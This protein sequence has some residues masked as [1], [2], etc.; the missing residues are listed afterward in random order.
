MNE[1]CTACLSRY[2]MSRFVYACIGTRYRK[3]TVRLTAEG[4]LFPLDR[5]SARAQR[6]DRSFYRNHQN[7][8]RDRKVGAVRLVLYNLSNLACLR[9]ASAGCHSY[10]GSSLSLRSCEA[11]FCRR[12]RAVGPWPVPCNSRCRAAKAAAV[13]PGAAR[14]AQ[15]LRNPSG[16]GAVNHISFAAQQSWFH[17]TPLFGAFYFDLVV[18]VVPSSY[19]SPSGSCWPSLEE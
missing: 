15:R 5:G 3:M 17:E 6:G 10:A 16:T 4:P 1:S 8:I 14:S 18:L 19:C 9:C 12:R 11:S 13:A 7:S 2:W